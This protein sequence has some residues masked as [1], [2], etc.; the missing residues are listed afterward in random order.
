MAE[1]G[2]VNDLEEL[3]N[4]PVHIIHADPAWRLLEAHQ[5]ARDVQ[6]LPEGQCG[7]HLHDIDGIEA[8]VEVGRCR[9]KPAPRATRTSRAC[10]PELLEGSESRYNCRRVR[11]G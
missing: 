4:C 7:E 3:Y 5:A 10:D 2:T 6:G 11:Q 1:T 8:F 9:E